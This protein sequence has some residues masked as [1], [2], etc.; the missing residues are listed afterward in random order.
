MRVKAQRH[1]AGGHLIVL[2]EGVRHRIEPVGQLG[3]TFFGLPPKVPELIE[4][5]G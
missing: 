4:E 1:V 5:V 3:E 2:H